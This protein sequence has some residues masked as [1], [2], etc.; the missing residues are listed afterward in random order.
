MHFVCSVCLLIVDNMYYKLFYPSRL[1]IH[2]PAILYSL[3]AHNT[4]YIYMSIGRSIFTTTVTTNK[5][6]HDR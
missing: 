3:Q 1:L 4:K 2:T 6:Y 5:Q